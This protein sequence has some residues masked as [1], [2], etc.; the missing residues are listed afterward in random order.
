MKVE[1]KKLQKWLNQK[2]EKLRV[3]SDWGNQ[4]KNAYQKYKFMFW[5]SNEILMM[6]YTGIIS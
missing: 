1:V 5:N 3:D 4:I 6:A 2:G